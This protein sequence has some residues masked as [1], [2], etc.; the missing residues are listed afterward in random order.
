LKKK[1]LIFLP[2]GRHLGKVFMVLKA[3]H[4]IPFVPLGMTNAS[5]HPLLCEI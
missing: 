3:V 1:M 5:R 4:I 2:Q